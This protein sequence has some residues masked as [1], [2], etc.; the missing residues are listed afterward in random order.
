[1]LGTVVNVIAIIIGSILGIVL[2]NGI[3]DEYKNTIMDGIGLVVIVIGIMSSIKSDNIILV[4]ASIVLGTLIGEIVGI[5]ERLDNLGN[6][7]G[8]SFGSGDSDFSK[9]FI[10]SSLVFCV[11]AMA[12]VG[13]LE[14]GLSGNNETLYAKSV[15]DGISA[16]I[17]AS[18][19]GIGVAFSSILVFLYQGSITFLAYYLKDILTTGVIVEMSAV[20]GVLIMAI[21][22]NI[23]SIKKLKVG[24]M[25][26]AVFI[27]IIYQVILNLMNFIR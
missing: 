12:I 10:T 6:K 11:G 25:L 18:T 15:L 14:A 8:K 27:P 7:M 9:A 26:P 17:F 2:K 5:E 19:L 4:I 13:A 1:M 16:L 23:L 24:N 21:G 3:K 20:G 22:M